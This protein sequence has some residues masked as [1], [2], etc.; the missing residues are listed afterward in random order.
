ML[1]SAL[2]SSSRS[3]PARLSPMETNAL[4]YGD[5]GSDILAERPGNE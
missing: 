4:Y 1:T 3:D 5:G 2:R